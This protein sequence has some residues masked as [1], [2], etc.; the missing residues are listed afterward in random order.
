[1]PETLAVA[2]LPSLAELLAGAFHVRR[3]I[4]LAAGAVMLLAAGGCFAWTPKYATT[5]SLVMLLGPE[6]TVQPQAGEAAGSTAALGQEQIIKAETEILASHGLHEAVIRHIGLARLYPDSLAPPGALAR[7]LATATAAVAPLLTR[8][9]VD[10]TPAPPVDPVAQ[11]L[12]RFDRHLEVLALKDGNVIEI[13]FRHPNADVAADTVNF[14]IDDYLERRRR[15]YVDTQSAV[16]ADGVQ[17][18]RLRLDAAEAALAGFKTREGITDFATDRNLLLARRDTLRAAADAGLAELAGLVGRRAELATELAHT[19]PEVALS[20]EIDTGARIGNVKTGMEDLQGK[21]AELLTHFLPDSRPVLDLQAQIT[22]RG[23][24][25]SALRADRSPSATRSGRNSI[26]DVLDLARAQAEIDMSAAR[27]RGAVQAAQ[28]AELTGRIDAL[29][30]QE[31]ELARLDR[32]RSAREEDYRTLLRILNERRIVEDLQAR[33]AA[34]ARIV[35]RAEPPPQAD[36]LRTL[37]MIGGCVLAM[38]TGCGV[39]I[40]S[41]AGRRSFLTAAQLERQLGL[42]VLG[43]IPDLAARD[44]TL[45]K[46]H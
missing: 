2:S 45:L 44:L 9:G 19:P 28:L 29:A 5:A 7:T 15:I 39:A 42:P 1:M 36:H 13:T 21:L 6:Y 43:L 3:R 10:M 40:M 26:Y 23:S 27:A 37:I 32:E 16:V 8:L 34:S 12:R 4:L 33:T 20:A 22:A 38:V 18:A 24:M 11:S 35:Q 14:L 25:L 41:E 17:A 30:A 31:A 46:R